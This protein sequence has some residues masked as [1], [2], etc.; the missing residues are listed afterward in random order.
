MGT[1]LG[2]GVFGMA[3][4]VTIWLLP[5]ILIA[6]SERTQGVEKLIWI[7]LIFFFSWFSWVLYLLLA[8]VSRHFEQP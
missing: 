3:L 6:R 7:L 1:M 2:F 4:I 8:P 5:A